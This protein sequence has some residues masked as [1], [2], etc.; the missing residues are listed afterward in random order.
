MT[1]SMEKYTHGGKRDGAGRRPGR[2]YTRIIKIRCTPDQFDTITKM[3]SVA[4][5]SIS[6]YVRK[7]VLEG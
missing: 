3:A 5:M 6:E 2:E 7:K 1:E 4:G